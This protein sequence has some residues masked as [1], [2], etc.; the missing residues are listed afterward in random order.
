MANLPLKQEEDGCT[1]HVLTKPLLPLG[2]PERRLVSRTFEQVTSDCMHSYV[3][4]GPT[5]HSQQGKEVQK[6]NDALD[7]DRMPYNLF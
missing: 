2:I 3:D 5:D 7:G 6:S 4:V 1:A